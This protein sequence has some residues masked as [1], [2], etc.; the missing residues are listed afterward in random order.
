MPPAIEL[1]SR[2]VNNATTSLPVLPLIVGI[3]DDRKVPVVPRPN[4]GFGYGM[5]GNTRIAT[6]LPPPVKRRLL[7][8]FCGP[9][10]PVRVPA[11]LRK[12]PIINAI[13]DPDIASLALGKLKAYLAQTGVGCFNHPAAILDS[14]RDR[15]AAKLANIPGLHVPLTLRVKIE[16][17]ADL[18]HAAEQHGLQWPLIVRLPGSHIGK[19]TIRI[20]APNQVLLSLRVLAWGG[21]E[22]YVTEYVD[23]ADADGLYRKI[24]Y[25]VVGDQ[26]FQRDMIASDHWMVHAADRQPGQCA[27]EETNTVRA[28]NSQPPERLRNLLL[29]V[30]D[31]MDLDYFGMD[32]SLRPDGR[33]LV[34]EVNA[35]MDALNRVWTPPL[36]PGALESVHKIENV[37][38]ELL[39]VPAR[40]RY[41]GCAPKVTPT[42]HMETNSR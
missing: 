22:L 40:W 6:H 16:E 1:K 14:G 2:P 24:R 30:A 11:P 8:I 12:A 17:P 27:E 9:G 36:P 19:N 21:C 33:L 5:V 32:C 42:P 31:V 18:V 39:F 10:M 26:V 35:M 34:F 13:A 4:G 25:M 7:R 23:F 28:F 38:V 20:D 15:V 3:P 41:P 29:K 37:V